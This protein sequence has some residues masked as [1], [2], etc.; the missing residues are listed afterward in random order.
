MTLQAK[1]YAQALYG[2][3]VAAKAADL[4]L[5]DLQALQLAISSPAARDQLT[6]PDVTTAERTKA[7][8]DLARGRHALVVNLLG[9]LHRRHRLE[10]LF[11]LY[12]AYRALL[13]ADRGEVDGVV[14]TPHPLGEA[15]VQ[16]LEALA[17]RLSG[18]KVSLTVQLRSDLLGGVSLRVGNELYD[19]SMKSTL[20]QLQQQL[21]Q[22]SITG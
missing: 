19:G 13:M 6:S 17:A 4:V 1:R 21:L 8:D 10:V 12:P 9:V 2:S 5:A 18:K 22:A 14:Q 7:L 15:E 16:A 20:A 11:A 3:A